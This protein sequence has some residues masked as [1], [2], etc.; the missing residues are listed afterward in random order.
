MKKIG[1]INL[2][3]FG[4]YLIALFWVVLGFDSLIRI[5]NNPA[6]QPQISLVIAFLMFANAAAL[7]IC[8]LGIAS[9]KSWFY[10]L[11]IAVLAVNILLTVTDQF[12]IIDLLTLLLDLS[13]LT[14]LLVK[15]YL[16]LPSQRKEGLK[17]Q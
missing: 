10:L 15:R 17:K 4:F 16:F 14:L 7:L 8:G 9:G 6:N 3:R 12:G 11:A 13:L 1:I 5:Q 2:V